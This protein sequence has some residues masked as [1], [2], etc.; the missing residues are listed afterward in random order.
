MKKLKCI[1]SMTLLL[2]VLSSSLLGCAS[3]LAG[4]TDP[5][6][7]ISDPIGATVSLN[8]VPIG[9]TPMTAE[10]EGGKSLTLLIEKQGYE[11]QAYALSTKEFDGG[12]AVL[13]IIAGTLTGAAIGGIISGILE[14]WVPVVAATGGGILLLAP[15]YALIDG[16]SGAWNV[17]ATDTVYVDLSE[18][19]QAAVA[20]PSFV[21]TMEPSWASLE[22]RPDIEYERAW[23]TVVDLLVKSFELEVIS[24]EDGYARTGWVYT[25]GGAMQEDY[26]V[27]V[28]VKFSPDRTILEVKSEAQYG[29]A[30][31][32]VVG[33]DESLL[34]VLKTDI[35]GTIGRTTR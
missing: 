20:P 33:T 7:I 22:L 2:C 21:R 24:K 15:I 13:D 9:T 6:Q 18:E 3:V 16:S 28:T 10:V 1:T 29:G 34:S 25:W 30:G 32:W 5:V 23:D 27:R 11:R 19:A 26:R 4:I 12:W 8:G 35:M 31:K 17:P 14:Y